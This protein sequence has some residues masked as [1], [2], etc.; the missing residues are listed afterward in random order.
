MKLGV[1][2]SEKGLAG[3][4][5]ER[6]EADGERQP[7]ARERSERRS[8]ACGQRHE[9]AGGEHQRCRH[10]GRG[11]EVQEDGG[12]SEQRIGHGRCRAASLEPSPERQHRDEAEKG[13]RCIGAYDPRVQDQRGGEG[14]RPRRHRR[15]G[16]AEPPLE[17]E[18]R[19]HQQRQPAGEDR[20][21]ERHFGEDD[22][23][24]HQQ[25]VR[26]RQR[27]RV[28]GGLVGDED[29]AERHVDRRTHGMKLV[30]GEDLRTQMREPKR[31]ADEHGSEQPS[32][33]AQPSGRACGRR[34]MW[35][36][37]ALGGPHVGARIQGARTLPIDDESR[38]RADAGSLAA[39]SRG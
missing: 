18:G 17:R 15:D 16:A 27:Y 35:R 33:V 26:R 37:R 32:A 2:Q 23:R 6:G 28:V 25:S 39:R 12:G 1:E 21:P 29:L 10:E 20:P 30:D 31:A 3:R 5:Q 14:N 9:R 24:V 22:S 19:G 4:Q 7:E 38:K 8:L 13:H 36:F 11:A 34:G